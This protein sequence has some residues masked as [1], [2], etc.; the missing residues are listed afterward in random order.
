MHTDYSFKFA[1]RFWNNR[2]RIVLGGKVSTGTET[3]QN[4]SFLT[5]VT[6]EYR[7]SPTSNQYVKVFYDRDSYDWLEGD[8]GEYG[9][10]FLWRRK[11]QHFKD[12]FSFKNDNSTLMLRPRN[13]TLR[14][15]SVR[16]VLLPND[17][18]NNRRP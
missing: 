10:G 6:F 9:V 12:I 17:S 11:L 7:L 15:D 4:Q 18:I 8:V 1:K 14:V 2:L 3:T 13:D 5:N 16:R